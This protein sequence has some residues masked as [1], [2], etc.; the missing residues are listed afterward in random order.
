LCFDGQS[1][2]VHTFQ[3]V[4]LHPDGFGSQ[5]SGWPKH[6]KPIAAEAWRRFEIGE[7]S[8]NELY[9][10][11]AAKARISFEREMLKQKEP[12]LFND[13]FAV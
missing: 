1:W 5:G 13:H 9:C 12:W 8:D 6:F 2:Q 7:L 4:C 11:Q 3:N 10:Y